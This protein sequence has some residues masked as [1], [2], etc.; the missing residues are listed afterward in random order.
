[1]KFR[2]YG[3]VGI[4]S[5][6][7]QV[8]L[9]EKAAKELG[10]ET[11]ITDLD[12]PPS[13]KEGRYDKLLLFY[14]GIPALLFYAYRFQ[15]KIY[16]DQAAYY[17]TLEG[18]PKV[19]QQ[20]LNILK[21]CRIFTNSR[22]GLWY[23][24]QAGLKVMGYYPH[25]IDPAEVIAAKQQ[26]KRYKEVYKDKFLCGYVGSPIKRK[27]LDLLFK[28]AKIVY[29]KY[30]DKIIFLIWSLNSPELNPPDLP[31]IVF[32]DNFGKS[33]HIE[34]MNFYYN[35]DLYVQP[36]LAEG[37]CIPLLEAQAMGCPAVAVRGGPMAELVNEKRGYPFPYLEKRYEDLG[38]GQDFVMYYYDPKDLAAAILAAYENPVELKEKSKKAAE[39]ARKFS[40]DKVYIPLI[41]TI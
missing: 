1:M 39:F 12:K 3:Q 14:C 9:I 7:K 41:R 19:N 25:A 8:E 4:L 30:G 28:A 11:Y 40:Y 33:Q 24:E 2:L 34:V 5:F 27:G 22:S 23:A 13:L 35:L 36:S 6:R 38:L 37:F 26:G 10:Y 20:Q 31:N 32:L 21:R 29:D 17:I 16:A 15:T 18:I